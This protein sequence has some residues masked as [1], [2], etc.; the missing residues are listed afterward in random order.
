MRC[1]RWFLVA[2]VLF[3]GLG[4]SA[5][6]AQSENTGLEWSVTPIYGKTY[7]PGLWVPLRV[8]IA[9]NGADQRLDVR[10]GIF[11]LTLDV[12]GGG[13]KTA[14]M[15]VQLDQTTRVPVALYAGDTKLATDTLE[16][17]P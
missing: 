8:N 4:R 13:Q 2:A 10:V 15:Y 5:A 17:L 6:L 11:S 7:R 1:I 3:L 14:T 16:V 9:N 12:P